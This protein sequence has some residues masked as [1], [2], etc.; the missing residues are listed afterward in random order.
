MRVSKRF[1]FELGGALLLVTSCRDKPSLVGTSTSTRG[2]ATDATTTVQVDAT[3]SSAD[4]TTASSARD[5]P[6]PVPILTTPIDG[7]LD[8]PLATELCWTL[9]DDPEGEPVRYRVFV[10]DIEL[11]EG[12][13]AEE[14]GHEGP[15]LGPLNFMFERTYTWQVEAIEADDPERA[16]GRSEA[17]S[18][19][20]V[21]DGIATVFADEFEDDLGWTVDGDAAAGAWIRAEPVRT[22]DAVRTAQPGTCTTGTRCYITGQNADAVADD[23]DVDG[24]ATVLVSPAFDLSGAAAATVRLSRFFYSSEPATVGALALELLVPDRSQPDGFAAYSLESM[25]QSTAVVAANAWTW[26]EYSA[27]GI[28]MSAGSRLRITARDDGAELVEAAIDS[29]RVDSYETS[30]LCTVGDV[31]SFC[32]PSDGDDAC[33]DGR[34]C[35][36]QGVVQRGVHRCTPAVRGI[37]RD[38]P[39]DSPISPGNGPLGCDAPDLTIDEPWLAPIFADIQF[40]DEA[41]ELI[42][43]CVGGAG[44]RKVMLFALITPNIGSMDLVLGVPANLPEL[45][46]FSECHMHSHFDG[47]ASY[48]LRGAEDLVASGH[49]Q[50]FCLMDSYGWA[51]P[52]ELPTFDCSNQGIRRGF[53]DIYDIGLPCQWVDVSDVTPGDYVLRLSVNQPLRDMAQPQLVERN[54]DN[55]VLDL[56]VTVP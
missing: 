27:C 49:K 30:E 8:V 38:A 33:S 36:A 28:P 3:A 20:T 50:A 13:L 42:E 32:D 55:N 51:W 22:V 44:L 12:R 54:Y 29:V 23:A 5:R 9:V 47:Y 1:A 21:D 46:H 34:L 10:D 56:P 45:F 26:R 25:Q 37:D 52:S 53:A 19:T 40:A 35:C 41:C 39:P 48:E 11:T 43:G 14:P 16:S 7:A 31:G 18:F 4:D 6:P 17:A 24:G 15:C 2:D